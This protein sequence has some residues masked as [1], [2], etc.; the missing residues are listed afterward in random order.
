MN[1]EFSGRLNLQKLGHVISGSKFCVVPSLW[2]ENMPYSIL[3]AF[4]YG[5]TVVA[6]RIG[7]IP[8]I[9]T[10]NVNG[11]LFE[12]GNIM[13]FCEK[14]N[15]LWKNPGISDRL[16]KKAKNDVERKYNSFIHYKKLMSAYKRVI[17]T[18]KINYFIRSRT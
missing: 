3:E 5:K 10:K 12:P 4:S 6:S 1:I 9:V 13:D 2:Y 17:R 11:E 15:H 18:R 14:I 16:G 8:E 7:G